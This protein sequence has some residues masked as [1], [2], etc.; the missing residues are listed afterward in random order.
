MQELSIELGEDIMKFKFRSAITFFF[1]FLTSSVLL[2][3]AINQINH[4]PLT[5]LIG[6]IL[7]VVYGFFVDV[8]WGKR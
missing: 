8:I 6:F 5:I 1:G 3:I 4:I 7:S 2:E